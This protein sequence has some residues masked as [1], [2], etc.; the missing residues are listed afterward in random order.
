MKKAFCVMLM[1]MLI[2]LAA[3]DC[4]NA[5]DASPWETGAKF[6]VYETLDGMEDSAVM[7]SASG[8]DCSIYIKNG[9]IISDKSGTGWYYRN[10]AA[11]SEFDANK[12]EG[13]GFYFE[14]NTSSAKHIIPHF[15]F[16]PGA[17]R[18]CRNAPVFLLSSNT[19]RQVTTSSN[20][21]ITL[22]AG[23]KGF[24]AVPFT[25]LDWENYLGEGNTQD[26]LK[27]QNKLIINGVGAWLGGSAIEEDSG[28]NMVFDNFFV[29]GSEIE[30][31]NGGIIPEKAKDTQELL[32]DMAAKLESDMAAFAKAS[33]D[34]QYHADYDIGSVKAITYEGAP[35]GGRPTR[36]F[37]YIGYPE[38]MQAGMKYPAVVLIHGAGGHA[39]ADWVKTW[40]G[41]GYIAIA[42]DTTGY[43]PDK[44]GQWIWGLDKSGFARSGYANSPMYDLSDFACELDRQ[45]MYHAVAQSILAK[46]VLEADPAVDPDKIGIVGISAGS[47]I[48]ACAIGFD[49]F[50]FAVCQYVA[51]HL[52]LSLTHN[53]EHPQK[54]GYTELWC[55]ESRF[56]NVDFPVLFEQWSQDTSASIL[57]TSA[58]YSDLLDKGA[59]MSLRMNWN[60][61]HDWATPIEIYRFA[62]SVVLNGQPLTV[63]TKQPDASGSINC[64]IDV[65]Q[66][67]SAV[68]AKVWYLTEKMSYSYSD[69]ASGYR[70]D[71]TFAS[72]ELTV[73]NGTVTGTLP[74][75][76]VDFYVE[77]ATTAGG[78]TYYTAS[79]VLTVDRSLPAQDPCRDGHDYQDGYC[80]RCG[81]P[82]PQSDGTA[83]AVPGST[84]QTGFSAG[85]LNPAAILA[86][87]AAALILLSAGVLW[88]R[89][90]VLKR[91][92]K[93]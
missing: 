12:A 53:A 2:L 60:H 51:G 46:G 3:P 87:C 58:C 72:K 85:S 77:I 26:R 11:S 49:K 89:K 61:Y 64:K 9:R 16:V 54:Q 5:A 81:A 32:A 24:V 91:K 63:I 8:P 44:S 1:G 21:P 14:N 17:V 73:N 15:I 57:S 42:M 41:K 4:A 29:Y 92:N 13:I 50:A 33:P 23:F 79:T 37:A 22:P 74:D 30:E 71:Q 7:A 80:T 70:L 68:K 31:N 43:F 84:S 67:A 76:A 6:S 36:V 40:N 52:E 82:Q 38:N 27:S 56:D 66:D 93:D 62:D 78:K 69:T 48:S 86:V 28:E 20:R 25:S 65:P 47:K 83:T 45:W 55:P 75:D 10:F 19:V 59:I 88:A 90:A 34:V 18:T 39:Y 35:L